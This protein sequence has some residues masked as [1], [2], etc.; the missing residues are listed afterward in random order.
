MPIFKLKLVTWDNFPGV[1]SSKNNKD[2]LN[3]RFSHSISQIRYLC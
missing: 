1:L 3:R 2:S